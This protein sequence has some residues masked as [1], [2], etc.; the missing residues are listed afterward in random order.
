MG[1]SAKAQAAAPGLSLALSL[2]AD[3]LG[4]TLRLMARMHPLPSFK[5]GLVLR[6]SAPPNE[7][8]CGQPS[9][10]QEGIAPRN[11]NAIQR[12]AWGSHSC[13]DSQ[14]AGAL[15]FPVHEKL[16]LPNTASMRRRYPSSGKIFRRGAVAV[17]FVNAGCSVDVWGCPCVYQFSR[18]YAHRAVPAFQ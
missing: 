16:G 8:G 1:R 7:R 13:R 9:A 5:R 4:A 14:Q 6:S 18:D 3:S 2:Q 12:P 17:A 15:G 10:F 11:L